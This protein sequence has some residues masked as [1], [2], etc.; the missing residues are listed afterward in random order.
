[1]Q[2]K[3]LRR[4]LTAP[5]R[6]VLTVMILIG[7]A[8]VRISAGLLGFVSAA[9]AVLGVLTMLAVSA[10]NG[11]ILLLIAVLVSPVGLPMAAVLLLG[12]LQSL[13]YALK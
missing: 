6:A 4:L 11:L 12:A 3:P 9:I 1:M 2:M 5:L 8:L 13:R 10:R 7:T